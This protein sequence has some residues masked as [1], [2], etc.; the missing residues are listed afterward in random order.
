[1]HS[2]SSSWLHSQYPRDLIV[3]LNGHGGNF[4]LNQDVNKLNPLPFQRGDAVAGGLNDVDSQNSISIVNVRNSKSVIDSSIAFSHT[5]RPKSSTPSVRKLRKKQPGG[6]GYESAGGY[7]N[8]KKAKKRG[9]SGDAMEAKHHLEV[10]KKKSFVQVI[11]KIANDAQPPS[12][13]YETDGGA[14]LSTQK[15]KKDKKKSKTKN[16]LKE[17]GYETDGGYQSDNN[18]KKSK[19]RFF[20]LPTKSLKPDFHVAPSESVPALP[21]SVEKKEESVVP[22]PIAGRFARTLIPSPTTT[23]TESA[24][25]VDDNSFPQISF[26]PFPA[27]FDFTST[28]SS[29]SPVSA[30]PSSTTFDRAQ[31]APTSDSPSAFNAFLLPRIRDSRFSFVSSSSS[32]SGSNQHNKLQ[33][34]KGLFSSAPS[35]MQGHQQQQHGLRSS[36][37]L[38][39]LHHPK[40]AISLPITRGTSP[41]STNLPLSSTRSLHSLSASPTSTS[42]RSSISSLQL[43]KTFRIKLHPDLPTQQQQHSPPAQQTVPPSP[44]GPGS[45][46]PHVILA[47]TTLPLLQIPRFAASKVRPRNPPTDGFGPRFPLTSDSATPGSSTTTTLL[48]LPSPPI[49]SPILSPGSSSPSSGLSPHSYIQASSK[50]SSQQTIIPSSDYIVPSPTRNS[51]LSTQNSGLPSPTMLTTFHHHDHIPPQLSPAPKGPLPTPPSSSENESL[52]AA[53]GNSSCSSSSGSAGGQHLPLAVHLRQRMSKMNMRKS[54][55]PSQSTVPIGDGGGSGALVETGVGRLRIEKKSGI[56]LNSGADNVPKHQKEKSK[57]AAKPS[58]FATDNRQSWIDL[59]DDEDTSLDNKKE[60][61]EVEVEEDQEVEEEEEPEDL[62]EILERFQN[63]DDE[64]EDNIHHSSS[65][66]QALE[67]SH[68]FKAG[69]LAKEKRRFRDSVISNASAQPSTLPPPPPLPLPLPRQ[70]YVPAA[71]IAPD[72]YGFEDDGKSV[73]DRTSRWSES[74]YSRSSSSI[75][76]E[77]ESEE[78][79]D[80]LLRRVE[81]MLEAERAQYAQQQA[82]NNNNNNNNI[83]PPLP[84]IPRAYANI[85]MNKKQQQQPNGK[86]GNSGINENA[87][88]HLHH[89]LHSNNITPG[90]SWNKF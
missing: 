20:K 17:I 25:I 3:N 12:Q 75:L 18:N 71:V 16:P 48:G 6:D 11:N 23:T 46:S 55:L 72:L 13:G 38:S 40:P 79:R 15:S 10:K 81:A 83:V 30:G 26:K 76:D 24:E 66:E 82:Y 88:H 36:L 4:N 14:V 59:M 43:K 74:V 1:M 84:E 67:R 37:S 34:L 28:T 85:I 44:S 22:L 52:A 69:K 54:L 2:H 31:I 39:S 77:E 64:N 65:N 73:G 68:S 32:G 19:S 5:I 21:N 41:T 78:R 29:S 61:L 80:R 42:F 86:I 45:S 27:T 50:R 70:S 8:E 60:K 47:P 56:G 9:K 35:S 57:G 89:H 62:Y 7:I 90:R 53:A 63:R 49:T 87:G 33:N 51:P 58:R